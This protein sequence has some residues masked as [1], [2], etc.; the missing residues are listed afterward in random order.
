MTDT[1]RPVIETRLFPTSMSMGPRTASPSPAELRG[2]VIP[3]LRLRKFCH[4]VSA[5]AGVTTRGKAGADYRRV[6]GGE[7]SSRNDRREERSGQ[8]R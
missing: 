1:T 7:R 3:G 2:S 5:F 6:T 4:V 8:R